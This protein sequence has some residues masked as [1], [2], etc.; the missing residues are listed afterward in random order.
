MN[1]DVYKEYINCSILIETYW[2]VNP[3]PENG[4]SGPTTILIETYWNVN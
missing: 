1:L 2:N 4:P 3:V